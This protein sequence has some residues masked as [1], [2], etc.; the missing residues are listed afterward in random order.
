MAD[1]VNM[2]INPTCSTSL[3]RADWLL[4]VSVGATDS[5]AYI[6]FDVCEINC[7]IVNT[8]HIDFIIILNSGIKFRTNWSDKYSNMTSDK[9]DNLLDNIEKLRTRLKYS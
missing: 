1:F 6:M 2:L 4:P 7:I 3:I 9:V 8:N 5:I